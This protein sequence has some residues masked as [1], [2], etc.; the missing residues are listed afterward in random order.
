MTTKLTL[1]ALAATAALGFV[2]TAQAADD[3]STV[4]V[5][6]SYSDLNLSSPDGAKA[7]LRRITQAAKGICG[8][9][10]SSADL[11]GR[12]A[13]SRCV[14]QIVDHAVTSLDQ[15]MVTAVNAGQTVSQV[16]S[17]GR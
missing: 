16:A 4:S 3:S 12:W 9:E 11:G 8:A 13:Y 15:P 17:S 7:V 5:R 2:S 10:P 1:I 6:V 14:K